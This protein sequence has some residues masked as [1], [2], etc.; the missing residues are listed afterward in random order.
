MT[1]TATVTDR[2]ALA[3]EALRLRDERKQAE[4]GLG[5]ADSDVLDVIEEYTDGTCPEAC[6]GEE[7]CDYQRLAALMWAMLVGRREDD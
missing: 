6:T 4:Y 5:I 2:A 1:A 3:L 7:C